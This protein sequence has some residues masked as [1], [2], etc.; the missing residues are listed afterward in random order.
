MP[1]MKIAVIGWGSLIWCPG[2]LRIKTKWRWD[3]PK[4]PIE[5][6]RISRDGRLTLVILPGAPDQ[7]TYWALSAFS[8]L[9]DATKNLRQREGS[10][11]DDI[12]WLT[13]DEKPNGGD[14]ID[15]KVS[16]RVKHWLSTHELDAAVWTGL[17]TNWRCKRGC[18]FT[19]EDAVRYLQELES[20]RDI[21]SSTYDRAQEYLEN[22]PL[23]IQ[24]DVRRA[25]QTRGWKDRELPKVLFEQNKMRSP[26][27]DR[28]SDRRN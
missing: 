1:A 4:L 26:K 3:G 11:S 7:P 10:K 20:K 17:S 21:A 6:A 16:K 9:E 5:F 15:G 12:H 8:N 24:T 2:S 23:Q 22:T 14:Q 28:K 18:D 13:E 25:M 27:S 19:T